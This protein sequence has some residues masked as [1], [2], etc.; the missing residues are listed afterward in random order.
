MSGKTFPH[1]DA[2]KAAGGKWN[3]E[4]WEVEPHRAEG[5]RSLPG[6]SFSDA[7][8]SPQE[9][10][11]TPTEPPLPPMS[12]DRRSAIHEAARHL[13]AH[14]PDMAREINGVGYNKFDGDFGARLAGRDRLSDAEAHAAAKMLAKYRRQLGEE[15]ADRVAGVNKAFAP[16][17]LAHLTRRNLPRPY[18]AIVG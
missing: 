17:T 9:P 1:K 18:A 7:P 12:E 10:T 2:I 13:A 4:A 6:L 14:D 3:G 8:A 16:A 11:A 5:I 15:L